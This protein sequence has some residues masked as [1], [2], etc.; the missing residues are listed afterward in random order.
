VAVILLETFINAPRERVFDLARSIDAH[1]ASAGD[2]AERAVAG[3]TTGLIGAGQQVTWE[4]RHFGIKQRL[5][6]LMTDFQPPE[7]FQDK[8]IRGAFK[9]MSHEHTFIEQNGGTLMRDKFDFQSPLGSFG[10]LADTL[11]LSAY[12]RRFLIERNRVLKEV[13]ESDAWKK[14][15]S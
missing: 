8:M 2:S 15:L 7:R 3:V 6:V 5:T 14:Y 11:V 9:R 10:Q 1:V 4:A 12:M 13:A